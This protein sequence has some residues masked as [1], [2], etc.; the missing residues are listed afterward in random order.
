VQ[1]EGIP[2]G[3][4]ANNAFGRQLYIEVNLWLLFLLIAI[5]AASLWRR[6]LRVRPGHCRTCRYNL[7]GVT[8]GTCPECGTP[9]S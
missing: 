6:H 5:P 2:W 9:H 7:A 4:L 8:G 1:L 3:W